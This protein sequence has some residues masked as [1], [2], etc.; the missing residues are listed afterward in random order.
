[1]GISE[2]VSAGRAILFFNIGFGSG[3]LLSSLMS[4]WLKSRKKAILAYLILTSVFCALFL[5]LQ[6]VESSTF[7]FCCVLLGLGAGYWAVFMMVAAEQFGTNLRATVATS[8]PN[9]VRAL[10]VPCS[11]ALGMMKSNLGVIG[12]LACIQT[13]ALISAFIAQYY[14]QETFGKDLNFTES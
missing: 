5:S 2:P 10:V 8:V 1:M 6:G 7:Y 4:Q 13:L 9:F 14:L 12:S 11:F 3:E